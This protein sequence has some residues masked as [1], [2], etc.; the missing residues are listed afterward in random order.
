MKEGTSG[1]SLEEGTSSSSAVGRRTG[2][3][4]KESSAQQRT[5]ERTSEEEKEERRKES[6][7][8]FFSEEEEEE[9]VRHPLLH[10]F[11]ASLI[12]APDVVWASGAEAVAL[13]TGKGIHHQLLAFVSDEGAGAVAGDVDDVA[14]FEGAVSG[15]RSFGDGPGPGAFGA[16][17]RDLAG[18][19]EFL[20]E[21]IDGVLEA[22]SHRPLGR[23]ADVGFGDGD[24]GLALV[25]V[26]RCGGEVDDVGLGVREFL[27]E[28]GEVA[29]RVLVRVPEVDRIGVVRVHQLDEAID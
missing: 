13:M 28:F 1:R 27:D 24:V 3:E 19:L 16:G 20:A 18:F 29:D 6:D 10:P 14:V 21:V 15:R 23:P 17:G 8:C 5:K 22:V 25:G 7:V 12:F 9:V 2:Q 11:F 26:V 4:K